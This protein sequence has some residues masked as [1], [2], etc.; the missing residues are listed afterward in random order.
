[1]TTGLL[2]LGLLL[3]ERRPLLS[4]VLFGLLA[5]KPQLGLLL[6]LVL[7][8]DRRWHAVAAAAITIA[9]TSL[10]SYLI[11]GADVWLAF[12]AS[13]TVTRTIV[14]E[15]GAMGW[16]KL[17]T[18]FAAMRMWGAGLAAAY[19]VQAIVSLSAAL[20]V[21][22]I[23]RRPVDMRLK[24]AA[25]VTGTLL[26]TPYVLDYDLMLL[27]LPIAWLTM[28]GLRTQF[29]DWEKIGLFVVW[30]LPLISREIGALGLP[31]APVVLLVLLSFIVRRAMVGHLAGH[32][33]AAQ[34]V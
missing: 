20:T 3:L 16:E 18:V 2:G 33:I 8:A 19:A 25:L 4:G 23:W 28:E 30:L 5:Y 9:T 34:Q 15:Q 31:I 11:F 32:G 13:V 17:Q 21:L 14:L 1:L 27:A 12:I 26:A 10:L 7:L 24:G 29:L 6:P 22:W